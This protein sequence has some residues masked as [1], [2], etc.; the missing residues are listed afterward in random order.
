[1]TSATD[2]Y[3]ERMRHA[4]EAHF[5]GEL[6]LSRLVKR[7]EALLAVLKIN[8]PEWCVEF[9]M[10]WAALEE[11]VVVAADRGD[12]DLVTRN[13]RLVKTVLSRLLAMVEIQLLARR[14]S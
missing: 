12:P 9:R 8:P 13:E 7:L 14:A 5:G 11:L 2:R 1:M 6:D 3:L 4:I 10:S